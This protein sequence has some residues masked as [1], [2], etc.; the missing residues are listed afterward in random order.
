MLMGRAPV[1][2]AKDKE[3]SIRQ[4][5]EDERKLIETRYQK[6][7]ERLLKL[8]EDDKVALSKDGTQNK[9]NNQK[10]QRLVVQKE[11]EL[12]KS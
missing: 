11:A 5:V 1:S 10:L 9:T 7:I 4:I 12:L 3:I 2:A 8:H 6:E